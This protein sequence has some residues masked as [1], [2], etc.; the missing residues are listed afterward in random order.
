MKTTITVASAT[1]VLSSMLVAACGGSSSEQQPPQT[2]QQAMYGQPGAPAQPAYGQPAAA[3]QP[4]YGQPAAAAPAA[5]PAAAAPAAA[6]VAAAPAAV[7]AAAAPAAD[8]AIA[9][10]VGALIKVREAKEA[11]GLK[12]EGDLIAGMIQEG[13]TIDRDVSLQ[14]GKCYT[15]LGQGTGVTQLDMTLTFKAPMA[16]PGM[17]AAVL[18]QSSTSGD[19]S[20]IGAGGVGKCYK[21]IGPLVVPAVLSIKATKGSGAAGAQVYAK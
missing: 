7:P 14:P 3:A 15:I 13:G 11:K 10:A 4:A 2:Q 6:P 18:A 1:I 17:P 16:I 19:K 12:A 9:A 21:T 20:A 8:Q 5:A